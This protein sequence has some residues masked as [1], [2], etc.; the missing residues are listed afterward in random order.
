MPILGKLGSAFGFG[1]TRAK[2][3]A[4]GGSIVSSGDN[5]YHVFT[6]PGTFI[7]QETI[8]SNVEYLIVAGGGGSGTNSIDSTSNGGGGG[9]GGVRTGSTS[10]VFG[11]SYPISVGGGGSLNNPR[12]ASGTSSSAFSITAAGGGGGG[13]HAV[14]IPGN[15]GISGGSGGSGG[16]GGGG[17][18]FAVPPFNSGSGGSGGTGNTPP[19]SPPQG[20]SGANGNSVLA[21]NYGNNGGGGGAG[22][23]GSS[24]NGGSGRSLSTFPVSDIGPVMPASWLTTVSAY[25]FSR[26]GN[27]SN[28]INTVS[29]NVSSS[30]IPNTIANTGYGGH[31][32]I[33]P[34]S[35]SPGIVIIKYT[36]RK[37]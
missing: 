21:G 2:I 14:G 36:I 8:L 4:T 25:G 34:G 17:Y 31:S 6:S 19:T 30:T 11:T 16:G 26:G 23:S 15:N 13:T 20:N 28:P 18:A 22:G 7:I 27:G 1:S 5:V 3:Y 9:A 37:S 12:G 10:V 29:Y 33:Y 24:V 35:G 32:N